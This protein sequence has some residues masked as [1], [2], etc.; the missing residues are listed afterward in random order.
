MGE[1]LPVIAR[2]AVDLSCGDQPR[3]PGATLADGRSGRLDGGSILGTVMLVV[4][5]MDTTPY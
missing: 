5:G 4:G 3:V 1:N 2:D